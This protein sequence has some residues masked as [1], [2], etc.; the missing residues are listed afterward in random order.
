[1]SRFVAAPWPRR[2]RSR[3]WFEG[4]SKDNIY[5]RCWMK[6]QGLPADLFD[7]RPV[8]GILQHLVASSP[9]ATPTCATWPSGCA[10]AST[11]RAGCRSSS[12][13]SRPSESAFRPDGDDVPQPL[14]R[15][16]SRRRSAASRS[17]AS[18]CWSGCDKTTPALLMGAACVD[19]PAILVSGGPMLNGYFRGERVGSGTALWKMLRGREG[20]RDD[21]RPISSRPRRR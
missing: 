17:T 21:R 19:L 18:C 10:T 16:T 13:C 1:M 6:N 14:P 9:P 20:R 7:G 12:R 15:W 5:H 3:E 2:L 4:T 11:R 8:I